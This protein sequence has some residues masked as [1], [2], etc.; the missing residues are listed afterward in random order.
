MSTILGNPITLG[1][2]GAKLNIDY[3]SVPPS[4]TSK[5]WV[6]LANKPD[7][8]KLLSYLDGQVG[9]VAIESAAITL[10]NNPVVIGDEIWFNGSGSSVNKVIIQKYNP[11]TGEIVNVSNKNKGYSNG[12]IAFHKGVVYAFSFYVVSGGTSSKYGYLSTVNPSTGDYTSTGISVSSLYSSV[13]CSCVS[14]GNYLYLFGG[15]NENYN[16]YCWQI[17]TDTMTK[18]KEYTFPGSL[19]RMS[20]TIY[21]N[22]AIYFTY[23]NTTTIASTNTYI[24]KLDLNT[25]EFTAI[26][27]NESDMK[28]MSNW[29]LALDGSTVFMFGASSAGTNLYSFDLQ[30]D[31][32]EPTIIYT[33]LPESRMVGVAYNGKLYLPNGTLY[34]LPFYR[35]LAENHLAIVCEVDSGG[36]D[37]IAGD[38][39]DIHINPLSVY[40]GDSENHTEKVNAYLYDEETATWVSLSGVSMTADMLAALA[41]LGVT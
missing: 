22:G 27:T 26:Y 38:T 12:G 36:V 17:D 19:Y 5:L 14:D 29:C 37:I 16:K 11:K 33:A 31:A 20:N 28:Q 9:G 34:S 15:G 4:D 10:E 8:V 25:W 41:T 32:I 35:D 6:P 30:A 24:G 1:G 23:H 13:Y 18:V 40:L 21:Y 3:G 39:V 2:G 7:A